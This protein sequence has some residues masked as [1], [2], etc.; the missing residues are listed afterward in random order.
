MNVQDQ[1]RAL[2]RADEAAVLRAV[3]D[4]LAAS[5]V[6]EPATRNGVARA[7]EVHLGERHDAS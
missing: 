7:I 1:T 6:P 2:L 4:Y 5:Y 3:A